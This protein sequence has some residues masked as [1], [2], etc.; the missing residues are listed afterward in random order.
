M[1][2]KGSLWIKAA[3]ECPEIVACWIVVHF[4]DRDDIGTQASHHFGCC[5]DLQMISHTELKCVELLDIPV[6]EAE[7]IG[8]SWPYAHRR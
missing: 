3:Q 6:H 2:G 7:T 5:I 8:H 1:M 4:I